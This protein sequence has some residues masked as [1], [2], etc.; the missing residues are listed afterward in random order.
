[1]YTHTHAQRHMYTHTQ[2]DTHVH[3]HRHMYIHRNTHTRTHTCTYTHRHVHTHKH[4]HTHIHAHTHVHT[5]THVNTHIHVYKYTQPYKNLQ[6]IVTFTHRAGY[7]TLGGG[8]EH[9]AHS[10]LCFDFAQL[11]S[12]LTSPSVSDRS[13]PEFRA[14]SARRPWGHT[15]PHHNFHL[16]MRASEWKFK[17]LM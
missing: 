13:S 7:C 6:Y 15:R 9:S 2:T 11:L 12:S 10:F 1:M 17:A 3:T 4:T 5:H 8:R 14:C 16:P